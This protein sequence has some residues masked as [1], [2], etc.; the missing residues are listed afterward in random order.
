MAALLIGM[1]EMLPEWS[2]KEITRSLAENW[3]GVLAGFT[4]EVIREAFTHAISSRESWP[5]PAAI[6]RICQGTTLNHEQTGQEI[7]GRIEGAMSKWGYS[8]PK[9]AEA[10]IGALGWEVVK[11]CGG[12]NAICNLEYDQMPSARKQWRDMGSIIDQKLHTTGA[13]LPPALPGQPA[14]ALGGALR[15]IHTRGTNS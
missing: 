13:D 14:P 5:A 4:D 2:P 3:Q 8:S 12:W 10:D 9:Q 15:L 1:K 6:K 7:A 11:R